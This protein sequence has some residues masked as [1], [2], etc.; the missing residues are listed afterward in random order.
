[1]ILSIAQG[2]GLVIAAAAIA[3]IIARVVFPNRAGDREE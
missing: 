3:F 1:M 2:L